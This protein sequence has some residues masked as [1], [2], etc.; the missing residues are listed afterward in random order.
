[1]IKKVEEADDGIYTCRAAVIP[2]G[3]LVE[4]NIRVEVQIKPEITS[5]SSQYEAIEG[6]EFSVKC[7]GRGKPVPEF[8]WVNQDQK[9]VATADR[10]SVNPITGQM[11]I[12]RVEEQDRGT[13]TCIARN[14]AGI[15]EQRTQLD[16]V[17]RPKV[18]E[19][20]NITIPLNSEAAIT[21]KATGRPAPEIT[22]RRWGT[23]EEFHVGQQDEDDRIILEQNVDDERGESQGTLIISKTIRSDDGLYECVARNKGDA[24]FKVGHITVEYPPNFEHLKGLPPVFSWEERT[25]NL[26][27]FAMGIPNATVE[28]TWNERKIS[29]MN[30]KFLQINTDGI[31]SDL[32]VTPVNRRYYSAFKCTARNRLGTAEI[33]MELREARI[34]GEVVQAKPSEVTATT[35]TFNIIAPATEIGLPIKAFSVQYKDERNLDWATARNRTWTPDTPYVVEGLNPQTSYNF[36]YYST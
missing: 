6:Q 21:C 17:V 32:M 5:L 36:R 8:I 31:R 12:S 26:S 35:V 33:L 18:Y 25:A 19:F 23:K 34:P 7:T 20:I 30:D 10:F 29:E 13:Y 1:M 2:T 16:I 11:S 15:A 22:F 24:A 28:W 27:C 9:E 14:S 3:E 4:R